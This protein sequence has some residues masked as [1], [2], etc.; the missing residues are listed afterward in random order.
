[1]NLSLSLFVHWLIRSLL[2]FY[3]GKAMDTLLSTALFCTP[4]MSF[5]V[6]RLRRALIL[7]LTWKLPAI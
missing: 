3:I 2:S 4:P 7:L 6:K 5:L 1:M